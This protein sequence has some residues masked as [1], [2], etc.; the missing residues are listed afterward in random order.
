MMPSRIC[1][2]AGDL[3]WGLS[4]S[5]TRRNKFLQFISCPVSG[6]LL[7]SPREGDTS[8]LIFP[9]ELPL[10]AQLYAAPLSGALLPT[11]GGALPD[12]QAPCVKSTPG[13]GAVGLVFWWLPCLPKRPGLL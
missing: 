7:A 5:R 11:A 10:G 3:I 4:V 6:I 1:E 8:S 9:P 13:A 2:S 12:T